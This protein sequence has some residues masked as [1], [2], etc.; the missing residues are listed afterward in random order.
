MDVRT[1]GQGDS[2]IH[3]QT[4]LAEGIINSSTDDIFDM[5]QTLVQ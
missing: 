3:P 5:L 4:L 2:Y 1:D